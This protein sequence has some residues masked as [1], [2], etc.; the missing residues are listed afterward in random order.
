MSLHAECT[1]VAQGPT[2][3]V[4][5]I[6]GGDPAGVVSLHAE[7][8]LVAQGTTELVGISGG[9]SAGVLWGRARQRRL[10]GRALGRLLTNMSSRAPNGIKLRD[11]WF[12]SLHP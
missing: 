7:C 3:L 1:R 2:E 10:A 5:I 6:G 9:E 11:Y 4:G 8:A 12:M